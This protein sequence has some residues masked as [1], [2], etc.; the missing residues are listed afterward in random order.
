MRVDSIKC[1]MLFNMTIIFLNEIL[2]K[3][4]SDLDRIIF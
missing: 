3:C 1:K 2:T 4:I